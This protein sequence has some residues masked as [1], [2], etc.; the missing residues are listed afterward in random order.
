D[1]NEIKMI[2]KQLNDK[3]LFDSLYNSQI[4]DSVFTD[5][6][7]MKISKFNLNKK[8]PA[9]AKII[10]TMKVGEITKPINIEDG[11][12]IIKYDNK[13]VSLISTESENIRLSKEAKEALTKYKMDSLSDS[14]VNK[15][16][17]ESNSTIKRDAFNILRSYLGKFIL[18]KEKYNS[19]D[20]D[21]KLETALNNLGISKNDKYSGID[22]LESA[23]K[24]YTLD[25]FLFWFQP[26][27]LYIKFNKHDLEEFSKSLQ[28]YVWQML[29]DNLLAQIAKEKNYY[30]NDW[31]KQQ[32]KWWK[33]KI[34]YSAL[35]NQYANSIELKQSEIVTP[36]TNDNTTAETMSEELT[37][38]ILH[39]ILELKQ[40]VKIN[41]NKDLLNKISVTSEEDKKAINLYSIKK[42]GLIPRPAYPSIDSDW[43]AWQ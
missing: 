28:N 24:N 19:W 7:E 14:Y 33:D 35:R 25:D 11:W 22:L 21:G 30:E 5:Q 37:Q 27:E 36:M 1:E 6:R 4:N 12:Y 13:I 2:F 43:A 20:L 40:N 34:V 42:G 9:L 32:S 38:K 17:F 8:N 18:S 23:D 10:D 15:I 39:K 29:R 26:R 31:V 16:L 41:I 3:S